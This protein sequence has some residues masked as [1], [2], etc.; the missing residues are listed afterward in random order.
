M[1]IRS[2]AAPGRIEGP[3]VGIG[4]PDRELATVPAG[5]VGQLLHLRV[6][7]G[8]EGAKVVETVSRRQRCRDGTAL[9]MIRMGGAG[10][11]AG[12]D[13]APVVAIEARLAKGSPFR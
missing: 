3:T 9:D 5:A 4:A 13:A 12:H 10:V 7:P 2:G 8:A 1:G 6:V 11:A